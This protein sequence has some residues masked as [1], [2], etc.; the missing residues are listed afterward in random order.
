LAQSDAELVYA[1][2]KGDTGA[3][4]NL[5][6]RYEHAVRAVAVDILGEINA[7]DDAAQET[8][9]KAYEKS[10]SLKKPAAFGP[11]LLRI[12]R[13]CALDA[14]RRRR[15]TEPL[16]SLEN[17]EAVSGNGRLDED[18]QELLSAVVRLPSAERQ[19]V[20]LRYFDQRSVR[21]VAEVC[22]RSVGTVTKQL[23]RAH[24]RLRNMLKG[25]KL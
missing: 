9:I 11:W 16:Q 25:R 4:A 6:R 5:V 15:K 19:V 14:A 17:V 3:F 18:K 23:S 21:Q 24:R 7:A 2:L 8:F 22:G 10:G 20:M 13:R 1:V 12:A